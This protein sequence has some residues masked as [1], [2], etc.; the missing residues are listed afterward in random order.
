MVSMAII[1]ELCADSWG[2][3]SMQEKVSKRMHWGR[4][5]VMVLDATRMAVECKTSYFV[6]LGYIYCLRIVTSGIVLEK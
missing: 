5:L 4:G 1:P 3:M 6:M 2:T